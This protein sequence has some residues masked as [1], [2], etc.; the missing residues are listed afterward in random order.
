MR[1]FEDLTPGVDPEQR[2]WFFD[3]ITY[4]SSWAAARSR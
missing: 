2:Y 4:V 1:D 3:E